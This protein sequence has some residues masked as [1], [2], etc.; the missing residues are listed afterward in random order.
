[1]IFELPTTREVNTNEP[2]SFQS[3]TLTDDTQQH[4]SLFVLQV[5]VHEI[6]GHSCFGG[7]KEKKGGKKKENR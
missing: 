4:N 3:H 7:G 1:M 6:T 2:L 5:K